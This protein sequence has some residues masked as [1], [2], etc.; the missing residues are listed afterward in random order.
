MLGELGLTEEASAVY[1]LMLREPSLSVDAIATHLQVPERNVRK[2]LDL[3]AELHLLATPADGDRRPTAIRPEIGL[4]QLLSRAEDELR[5]QQM[6]LQEARDAIAAIAAEV[7]TGR[8]ARDTIRHEGVEAVRVRLKTLSEHGR[9]EVCSFSP[10]GA[11]KPDAMAESKPL[12][13][14]A[15]ERGVAIRAVYQDAYR[16]DADTVAYAQW[17]TDLG[18]QIR[19]VP[20]VPMQLVIV[21]REIAIVPIS[22]SDPRVGA[23]EIHNHGIVAAIIALFEHVWLSGTTLGHATTPPGD[24]PTPLEVEVL[25]S[26]ADGATDET[27]ARRLGVSVRTLRRTIADLIERLHATSRFEAGVKAAHL[28]W[29]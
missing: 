19:T 26:L 2:A 27:I 6:R 23:T 14:L 24:G 5:R 7:G 15:L 3:L 13:Q 21:D 18:G 22:P 4:T 16:N 1:R 11:H 25:R 17:M 8:D 10:G 29:V 28:G 20:T 12:N 9:Y